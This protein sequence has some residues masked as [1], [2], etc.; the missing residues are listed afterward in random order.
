MIIL[1]PVVGTLC[2]FLTLSL[3]RYTILAILLYLGKETNDEIFN[4]MQRHKEL[5]DLVLVNVGGWLLVR[6]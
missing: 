3:S 1:H 2:S 6:S 5:I 4:E